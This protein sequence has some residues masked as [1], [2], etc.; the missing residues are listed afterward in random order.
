MSQLFIKKFREKVILDLEEEK[1]LLNHLSLKKLKKGEHFL[2]T[3]EISDHI[4]FIEK[5]VLRAYVLNSKG[6]ENVVLFGLEGWT[7]GDLNSFI[8][9][10][11]ATYNIDALEDTD[12]VLISKGSH[13]KLLDIMPKYESY[14]RILM[15]NAYMAIQKRTANIISLSL[16]K[17]YQIFV[18]TYPDIIQRVPQYMI[19][20]Y[21]GITPETLSRIRAKK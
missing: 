12:L 9:Q 5:G 16:D 15:T 7:M 20:S 21:M 1:I 2:Y 6:D 13:D 18:E 4:T 11:P 17:R 3:G 10:E 19:A 14:I 8:K